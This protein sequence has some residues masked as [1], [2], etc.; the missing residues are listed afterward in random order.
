VEEET[1]NF[2]RVITDGKRNLTRIGLSR[3]GDHFLTF[4]KHA[5]DNIVFLNFI[6]NQ[7]IL[8]K[9]VQNV[10]HLTSTAV[11]TCFV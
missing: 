6:I 4:V 3:E 2:T 5:L 11:N 9:A 8:C 7:E 1:F 10:K